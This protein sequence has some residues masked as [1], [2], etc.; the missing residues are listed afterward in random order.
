MWKGTPY[1]TLDVQSQERQSAERNEGVE[2]VLD[3][4]M[5][6]AWR[7][8]GET[9]TAVSSRIVTP[10]MKIARED[11]PRAGRQ[12]GSSPAY[13]CTCGKCVCTNAPSISREGGVLR[14][15]PSNY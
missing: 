6:L 7:E 9:W 3:P 10:R 8:A 1:S 5:A 12:N 2:I 11:E 13:I 14:G 4:R 15:S